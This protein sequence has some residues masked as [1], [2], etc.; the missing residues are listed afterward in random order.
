M[1]NFANFIIKAPSAKR[2][3]SAKIK[4]ANFDT[5][6]DNLFHNIE[7]SKPNPNLLIPTEDPHSGCV[8]HAGTTTD[9]LE[10]TA[11]F[12]TVKSPV[13][14]S[15]HVKKAPAPFDITRKHATS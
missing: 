7:E 3:P 15:K 5:P 2:I 4:T 1:I 8:N 11:H 9:A 14:D 10:Q 12:V 13:E 6:R